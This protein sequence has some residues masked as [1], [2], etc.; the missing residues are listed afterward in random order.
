MILI[1]NTS[2]P[3]YAVIHNLFALQY[4]RASF[5]VPIFFERQIRKDSNFTHKLPE[6]DRKIRLRKWTVIYL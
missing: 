4:L 6:I 1:M 2:I 3:I 5:T